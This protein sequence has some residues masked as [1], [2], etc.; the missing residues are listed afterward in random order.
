MVAQLQ[1]MEIAFDVIALEIHVYI[2][3]DDLFGFLILQTWFSK[4]IKTMRAKSNVSYD[5]QWNKAY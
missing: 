3:L 4:W 1:P 2:E 5:S